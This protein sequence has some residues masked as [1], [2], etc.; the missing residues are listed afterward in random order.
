MCGV[1]CQVSCLFIVLIC[2]SRLRAACVIGAMVDPT[3]TTAGS[4]CCLIGIGPAAVAPPLCFHSPS[5]RAPAHS[6]LLLCYRL[7]M[8]AD[9][10]HIAGYSVEA[11]VD[12]GAGSLR[13]ASAEGMVD[14]CNADSTCMG[15]NNFGFLVSAV[16]NPKPR[17]YGVCLY[18][19]LGTSECRGWAGRGL[20]VA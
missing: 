4:L 5:S 3:P 10:S 17:S 7:L 6:A 1:V 14:E 2:I 20:Q 9:C 16:S 11:D 19:K 13:W 8:F 15:F 12:G 18:T